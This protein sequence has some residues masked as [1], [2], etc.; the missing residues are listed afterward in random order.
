MI[1]IKAIFAGLLL[2]GFVALI[3]YIFAWIVD[4]DE[5]HNDGCGCL[6]IG[7]ALFIILN[8]MMLFSQLKSCSSSNP[9]PDYYDAPRK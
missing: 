6:I 1:L 7:L 5:K 4:K 2:I 9:S 3:G 8:L